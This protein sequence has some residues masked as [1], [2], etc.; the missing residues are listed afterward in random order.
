M[1]KE[2]EKLARNE[3]KY[4][5]SWGTFTQQNNWL[6]TEVTDLIRNKYKVMTPIVIRFISVAQSF[7]SKVG[8]SFARLSQ[9]QDRSRYQQVELQDQQPQSS[10]VEQPQQPSMYADRFSQYMKEEE[11][12]QVDYNEGPQ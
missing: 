1:V 2:E 8:N 3:K 11:K 10:V 6:Y 12:Q 7:F 9:I 5:T 4:Q